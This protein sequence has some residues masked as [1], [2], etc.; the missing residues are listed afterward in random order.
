[1]ATLNSRIVLALKTAMTFLPSAYC[2]PSK[3]FWRHRETLGFVAQEVPFGDLQS[4]QQSMSTGLSVGVGQQMAFVEVCCSEKSALREACRVARMPYAGVFANVQDERILEEMQGFVETQRGEFRWVH[5]HCSTPCCPGSPLK[6]LTDSSEP[7]ASDMEWLSIIQ[8]VERYLV[9]GD[10]KSF[11]PRVRN[12]IWK[13]PEAQTIL[14]RNGLEDFAD[15][16]LCQTGLKNAAREPVGKKLRL[17]STSVCFSNYLKSKFGFCNSKHAEFHTVTRK[18]TGFS[19]KE[20]SKAILA[21]A[22]AS[23]RDP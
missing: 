12:K 18:L 1:M 5:V 3:D 4:L 8:S 13:R 22:R 16:S 10:S 19:T 2:L 23:R 7:S 17:Y 20:L 9:L 15:V 14:H 11:E 6:H 21:A